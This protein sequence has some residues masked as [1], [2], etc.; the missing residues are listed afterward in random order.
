MQPFFDSMI[1]ISLQRICNLN[2]DLFLLFFHLSKP[3]ESSDS[4]IS[5]AFLM[6]MDFI[7]FSTKST[8]ESFWQLFKFRATEFGL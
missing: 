7:M 1:K 3:I 4:N 6:E 2:F 5:A 8:S